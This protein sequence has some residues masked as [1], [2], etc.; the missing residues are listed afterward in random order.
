MIDKA[1]IYD[2]AVIGGGLGGL[3]FAIQCADTG[4]KTILFEKE[5]YPYH[6]VCGEYIS[7]ESFPF[8][9][10]L[11]LDLAALNL[12]IIKL[13]QLSDVKGNLYQFDLPLGG[14]GISRYNLDHKLSLLAIEKGVTV[15]QLTRVNDVS[16]EDDVF[17]IQTSDTTYLAKTVVGAFGK[18]ANLDV[19]WKRNFTTQKPDK[20]NNWVGVKYHIRFPFPKENIALHNFQNGYCGISNIEEDQCCLCYLT[21]A[22][23]LKANENSVEKMEHNILQKNPL[24]KEIFDKATFLYAEPLSISQ[25]NFS[26]KSRV[27]NHVILIGDAAGLITPL[28]G[29][30][31]SMAMHAGKLAFENIDLFLRNKISR[32]QME[33]Q[34][35]QQWKKQFSTRL[36]IG[37]N[38]Q[39]IFGSNTTTSL[40][41][42]VMNK[43]P[44]LAKQVIKSTH[45]K[46]F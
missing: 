17:N 26:Q 46:A 8:L 27:E 32:T 19:K 43:L 14:F 9:H 25:V 7:M 13:L 40:F 42:S 10:R 41:L 5:T 39:K 37:R 22:E 30:G 18:R 31:M 28:C 4:Y 2:V 12:P 20:I 35:Q 16:F 45:G 3:T 15:L 6:K 33:S 21:R 24:L 44:W 36:F 1:S 38:V 29:N 11:G 23:N 34:Y